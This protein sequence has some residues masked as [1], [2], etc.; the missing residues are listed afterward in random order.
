M[1]AVR[2]IEHCISNERGREQ[3]TIEYWQTVLQRLRGCP[4]TVKVYECIDGDWVNKKTKNKVSQGEWFML[5]QIETRLRYDLDDSGA[6]KRG[7]STRRYS[8][9]DK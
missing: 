9:N 5:E 1:A 2:S 7:R 6:S 4:G 8:R 3:V